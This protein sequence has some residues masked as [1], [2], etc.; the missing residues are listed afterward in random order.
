MMIT[1][2]IISLLL[3]QSFQ[4]T[5]SNSN[6]DTTV[7]TPTPWERFKNGFH[8]LLDLI[9]TINSF[10]QTIKNIFGYIF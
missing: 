7:A 4:S 1:I 5:A 3:F 2:V 10:W 8:V 9:C 6:T